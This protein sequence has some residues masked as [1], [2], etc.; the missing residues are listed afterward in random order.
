MLILKSSLHLLNATVGPM[1]GAAL[2]LQ[3]IASHAHLDRSE[4]LG[5][6]LKSVG[7]LVAWDA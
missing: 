2:D 6:G 1:K 3:P 7:I 4:I 5:V